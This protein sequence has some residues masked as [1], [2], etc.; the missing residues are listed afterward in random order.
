MDWKLYALFGALVI[1][2]ALVW[3]VIFWYDARTIRMTEKEFQLRRGF[4]RDGDKP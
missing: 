3:A 4:R 1:G 2:V